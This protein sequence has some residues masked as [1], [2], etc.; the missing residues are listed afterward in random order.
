MGSIPACAGEPFLFF[1]RHFILWVYPRV[2]G[3]TFGC[4]LDRVAGQGLSPRV[5]GNPTGSSFLL[6]LLRSIPACAGEPWMLFTDQGAARVY[7]RVC[8]GTVMPISRNRPRPGLSPRVRGNHPRTT[9]FSY[10]PGSIPAC[11]GEPAYRTEELGTRRVYPRVCGGTWLRIW[12]TLRSSGLSPRV[13]GNPVACPSYVTR[14]GSIPACAGEPQQHNLGCYAVRVYP[15]VC[16]GTFGCGQ[17]KLF[18]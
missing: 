10:R 13:R 2:C 7:P 5:R 12:D 11:A 16:G 8:G 9:D 17:T 6:S 3:G 15:R 1:L 4:I 18:S 14:F